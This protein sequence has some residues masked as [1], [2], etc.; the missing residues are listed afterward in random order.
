TAAASVPNADS[1]EHVVRPPGPHPNANTIN[2]VGPD[3]KVA[4]RFRGGHTYQNFWTS[5]DGRWMLTCAQKE[6]ENLGVEAGAMLFDAHRPGGGSAKLVYMYRVEG[7]VF[8]H[9]DLAR[10][11]SAVAIVECPYVDPRTRQLTG[12]YQV[13]VLR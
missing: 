11:G 13:H 9:A 8:F 1:M 2:V 5:A 12:S 6:E 10:D 7:M 3:G 4:W